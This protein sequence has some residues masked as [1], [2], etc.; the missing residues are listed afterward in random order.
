MGIDRGSALSP[1]LFLVLM[2]EATRSVRDESKD[3]ETCCILMNQKK[4]QLGNLV[5]GEERWKLGD[6]R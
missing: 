3:Y 6:L 4:R 2:Q 1:L 5:Y